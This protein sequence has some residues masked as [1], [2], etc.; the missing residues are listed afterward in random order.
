MLS[1]SLSLGVV[2]AAGQL[3]E[4]LSILRFSC[5]DIEESRL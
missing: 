5:E 4:G 3:E 1:R 2:N